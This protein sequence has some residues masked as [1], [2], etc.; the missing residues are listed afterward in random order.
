MNNRSLPKTLKDTIPEEYQAKES[1][2][3][4]IA[5]PGEKAYYALTPDDE[6]LFWVFFEQWRDRLNLR[7][8]WLS[9]KTSHKKNHLAWVDNVSHVQRTADVTLSTHWGTT[10]P[11]PEELERTAVHEALHLSLLPL[12]RMLQ[13]RGCEGDALLEAEHACVN[14]LVEALLAS[15]KK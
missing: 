13:D 11:T 3:L 1:R 4:T 7:D 6:K 9:Y 8:W 2:P 14:P 10:E 12:S 5:K 15:R